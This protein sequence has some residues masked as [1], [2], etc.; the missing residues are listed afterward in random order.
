MKKRALITGVTGQDGGYLAELL[1]LKGYD[2]FGLKRRTSNINTQRIGHL[3][4]KITLLDGDLLDSFSLAHA[5]EAARPDEVYNLAA[6]SFVKTSFAQ[7]EYTGEST[8]LGVTRLLEAVRVHAPKARFY[9]A[10][11]SEMFGM[12]PPP[13]NE[14]SA[15]HPRSPYG[16]AKMYAY[17]LV[18]NYREAYGLYACNGMGFNHESPRRGIEFV[19]QKI[20]YGA[21]AIKKGLATDIVLGNLDAKRDWG[22]ARDFV[23]AMW[24]ML[25]ADKPKDYVIATGEVHSVREF[26][27]LAFSTLGL[28]YTKYVRVDDAF[29]RPSDV[30]YLCGDFSRIRNE[31]GWTP[32]T[33]FKELVKEM[34]E[35]A[36]ADKGQETK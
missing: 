25:Q 8:G 4:D 9:Q 28:D 5:V 27:E 22:H 33:T 11:S 17:W 7:P 32:K 2:V 12:S 29:K 3:L 36:M 24:L 14:D 23:E 15:F 31:L 16:C 35:S 30:E 21:A 18:I 1:L 10:S 26:C 13:Q 20:A 34:V 19:T 6:Q